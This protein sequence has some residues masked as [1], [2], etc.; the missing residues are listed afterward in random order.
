MRGGGEVLDKEL[1]GK[2]DGEGGVLGGVQAC[3][4]CVDDFLDAGDCVG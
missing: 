1:R 3:G 2:R 4:V